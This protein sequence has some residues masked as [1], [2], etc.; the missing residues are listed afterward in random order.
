MY[1]KTYFQ[2]HLHRIAACNIGLQP[3]TYSPWKRQWP[4]HYHISFG[5]WSPILGA[6]VVAKLMFH[7][8]WKAV[9]KH[10]SAEHQVVHCWS[11]SRKAGDLPLALLYWCP[12]P[13]WS[14]EGCRE[15]WRDGGGWN[16]E[17]QNWAAMERKRRQGG[18]EKE[19]IQ[20]PRCVPDPIHPF[21][22]SDMCQQNHWH[23]PKK[24]HC[25]VEGLWWGKTIYPFPLWKPPAPPPS[26]LDIAHAFLAWLHWGGCGWEG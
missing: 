11:T 3:V 26:S 9:V 14:R 4:R 16:G 12:P 21:L 19:W 23:R 1:N 24:T 5:T 18:C 10:A 2:G 25:S 15:G 7:Q 22:S 20:W 6:L 8:Y 13:R 17:E